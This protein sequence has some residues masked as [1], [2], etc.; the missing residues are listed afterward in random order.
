[1]LCGTG[2]WRLLKLREEQAQWEKPSNK[3]DPTLNTG[4]S[5]PQLEAFD[6]YA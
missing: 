3:P 1:M 2:F 4:I 6:V 5:S